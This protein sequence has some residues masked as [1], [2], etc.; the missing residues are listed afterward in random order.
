MEWE[1]PLMALHASILCQPRTRDRDSDISGDNES[2]T[3]GL[4]ILNVGFG[5]GIIDTEIQSYHPSHHAIIEAHPSVHERII[6][7]KWDQRP[8]VQVHFGKWQEVVPKLV[9]AGVKFDGIFFDTYGEHWLDMEDFHVYV[10]QLLEKSQ[11]VYSF[12]NGLAPDNVFFHGVGTSYV[13]MLFEH[14]AL[15]LVW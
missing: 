2:S 9:E 7:E 1:K 4:R 13:I 11:G 3:K 8:N 6:Q 5:M 10:G 15:V 14:R 12:F